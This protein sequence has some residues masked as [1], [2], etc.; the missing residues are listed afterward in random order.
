VTDIMFVTP[1]YQRY[2]LSA[3]CFEQR[4]QVIEELARHDIEAQCVVIADDENLDSARALGFDTVETPN[5]WL[6]RKFND[7]IEHA[8]KHGA[9][10]VVPIGSDSFID[11]AY[12][13]PLPPDSPRIVRT[14]QLYAPV[15]MER[16]AITRVAHR[17]NPAGP[18]MFH[19]DLLKRANY[20]PMPDEINRNTDSST[21]R[22][23]LP[24][25]YRYQDVHE[26]QYIGFRAP[27]FITRYD[28]LWKRWGIT[29]HTDPWERL[30]EHYDPALVERARKAMT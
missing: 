12:F 20:R 11:P 2:D 14:S 8:V 18:H 15:E 3:V 30:A 10:W 7:G 22:A 9:R 16:L 23:L 21:I 29:E 17:T 19:R 5:D 13:L 27:P 25:R 24:F 1:A 6:G 26:L 4:Q 28:I